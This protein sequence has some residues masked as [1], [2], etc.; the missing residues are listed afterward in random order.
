[1]DGAPSRT[2]P[3]SV[4]LVVSGGDP[5]RNFLFPRLGRDNGKGLGDF[6]WCLGQFVPE[7]LHGSPAAP[8]PAGT[9]ADPTFFPFRIQC[10]RGSFL[11]GLRGALFLALEVGTHQTAGRIQ[12]E[13]SKRPAIEVCRISAFRPAFQVLILCTVAQPHI[14]YMVRQNN[15]ACWAKDKPTY[16]GSLGGCIA[17]RLDRGM[18]LSLCYLTW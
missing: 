7:G 15:R 11:L 17:V 2:S 8:P 3:G 10:A 5:R 18:S 4:R 6:G 16:L 14:F 1:M 12:S 9:K 13:V